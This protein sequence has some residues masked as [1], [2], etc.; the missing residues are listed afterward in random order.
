MTQ[1]K[2]TPREIIKHYADLLISNA[3]YEALS[4]EEQG[5]VSDGLLY[6]VGDMEAQ[7][8]DVGR[9]LLELLDQGGK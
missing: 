1:T 9:L 7:S 2:P 6:A 4:Q 5:E 3:N 8:G